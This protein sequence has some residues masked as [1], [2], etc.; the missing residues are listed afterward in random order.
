MVWKRLAWQKSL[1]WTGAKMVTLTTVS[2]QPFEGGVVDAAL[3]P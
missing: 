2:H 1:E 3:N